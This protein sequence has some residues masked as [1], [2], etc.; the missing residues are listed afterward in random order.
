VLDLKQKFQSTRPHGARRDSS[1]RSVTWS[2]VSIH[3]PARGATQIF[4]LGLDGGLFQSTRPHGARRAYVIVTTGSYTFQSTRPHGA[5][6]TTVGTYSMD[7][8]FQSTRPHGARR[9]PGT[10]TGNRTGFNPRARTGR[11]PPVPDVF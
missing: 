10:G 8:M 6:H 2:P 9:G 11:D 3:A 5:R 4:Q 1:W 7:D